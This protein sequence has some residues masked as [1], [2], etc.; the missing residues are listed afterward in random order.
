MSALLRYG[1]SDRWTVGGNLQGGMR[2]QTAGFEQALGTTWGV[3]KTEQA[4]SYNADLVQANPWGS[5]TRF[6]YRNIAANTDTGGRQ[7]VWQ[8][9][10]N[11]RTPYF[12]AISESTALVPYGLELQGS[13]GHAFSE[14]LTLTVGQ[15]YR[16][17]RGG[18][19]DD[20][21]TSLDVYYRLLPQWMLNVNTSYST[22]QQF[23]M[24]INLSWM[25]K[26]GATMVDGSYDSVG[27]VARTDWSYRPDAMTNSWSTD[28][29]VEHAADGSRAGGSVNYLGERG[30]VR[31]E[32]ERRMA[33]SQGE[34]YGRTGTSSQFSVASALVY[35]GGTLAVA[36]PVAGSF[37]IVQPAVASGTAVMLNP[38]ET[39]TK[40]TYEGKSSWMGPAVLSELNPY[41]NRTVNADMVRKE[42][43]ERETFVVQPTYKSGTRVVVGK[44][45]SVT[46]TGYLK[47]ADNKPL[48]YAGGRVA[49]Q[50]GDIEPAAGTDDVP[51]VPVMVFTNKDGKFTLGHMAPGRYTLVLNGNGQTTLD[52]DVPENVESVDLGE[53]QLEVRPGRV[54]ATSGEAI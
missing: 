23:G 16:F 11:Y 18:K 26:D 4:V 51:R 33:L 6:E 46:V 48:E 13:Y 52:F 24:F 21:R 45:A 3:L 36:R 20:S 22:Q 17:G 15:D 1:L 38:Q 53:K 5:A 43:L 19:G 34:T 42:D 8:M 39:Q 44:K 54:L 47:D 7:D 37:A 31:V 41:M 10:V 2:R 25:G 14:D 30:T 12:N 27:Q 49:P 40:T 35:S 28:V 32:H 9:A 50:A 29:Q